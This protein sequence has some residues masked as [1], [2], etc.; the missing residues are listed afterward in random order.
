MKLLS[1]LTYVDVVARTGSIRKAAERLNIT[2]TALNR[3]I[4]AL[5]DELGTPIFERLAQGVRLNS[6]GELVIQHIRQSMADLSK[7]KSQIADL[8]GFRQGHIKI[9]GGSEV[10]GSFLPSQIAS[11]RRRYPGVSFEILRRAPDRAMRALTN[12]E[13]DLSLIFA[14]IPPT[15]YHI[16]ASV[17]LDVSLAM[18]QTHPLVGKEKISLVDCQAYTAVM[19]SDG[20]GLFDVLFHAQ[21]VRGVKLDSLIMSDSVEFMA[22]YIGYENAITFL[23]PLDRPDGQHRSDNYV[24]RPFRASERMTGRLHLVQAKGR[25]LPVAAAK[26]AE[27]IIQYFNAYFASVTS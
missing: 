15:E 26:F 10:I 16:L 20:T 18:A 24:T 14:P 12:L 7:V 13:A 6:A 8:Q 21:A 3:R 9:A 25:V 1:H 23:L 4:L 17:D 19:P 5:E 2:S 27:D 22:K 11:Y